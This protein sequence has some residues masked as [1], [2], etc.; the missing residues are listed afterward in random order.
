MKK[1]I[2]L[3]LYIGLFI[4]VSAQ[5]ESPVYYGS[6]TVPP[7]PT[8]A[9]LGK[10]GDVPVGLYTGVPEI[11]IPIYNI[12]E[13][14]LS[15]PISLSY[16]SQGFKV[17]DIASWVGLGWSLNGGGTITR[18]VKGVPDDL[19]SGFGTNTDFGWG[20][21]LPGSGNVVGGYLSSSGLIEDM[22]NS[23]FS[24][25]NSAVYS[26]YLA[27]TGLDGEPDMFYF[28][29]PG[30]SGQFVFDKDGNI[31]LL[32]QQNF[33][34]AYTRS[35]STGPIIKFEII[36][37]NGN[38]YTFD[39]VEQTKTISYTLSNPLILA[40]PENT[41]FYSGMH[42]GWDFLSPFNSSWHLTKIQNATKNHEITFTYSSENHQYLSGFSTQYRLWDFYSDG[43]PFTDKS[44]K[45]LAIAAKRLN[46]IT[47]TSGSITFNAT[48]N[49][50][51]L[52]G[53]NDWPTASPPTFEYSVPAGDAKA[54]SNIEIKNSA[55]ALIKKYNF[56]Y[57][58]FLAAN[59][60]SQAS[61]YKK[62][63]LVSFNEQNSDL[64]LTNPPYQFEYDETVPI[65]PRFSMR[66]DHW[67]YLKTTGAPNDIYT[68]KVYDYPSD[69]LDNDFLSEFSFFPRTTNN[70]SQVI[71]GNYDK[72]PDATAMKSCILKKITYP[73]KGTTTFEFE[74]HD[75]ILQNTTYTG[76]GLRIKKIT[77]YD[78]LDHDKDIIKNYS[79]KQTNAP[80]LSSGKVLTL[81]IF[82]KRG[83]CSTVNT[84]PISL[85]NT[86]IAPLG[87]T[88][89]SFVGYSEVTVEYNGNGK[90]ISKFHLPATVG[91]ED[92]EC[93][94]PGNCIYKRTKS[95]LTFGETGN[96]GDV[97]CLKD[98]FPYA[99]NPNYDWN[100][101]AL[102]EEQVFDNQN[103]MIQKTVNEYTIK[104]YQ[105]I[106]IITTAILTKNPRTIPPVNQFD[107]WFLYKTALHYYI[108]GW[109]VLSKQTTTKYDVNTPTSVF[110][111]ATTYSYENSGHKQIT[112]T[113]MT[114]SKG[115]THETIHKR[116][117]DFN[118]N[119]LFL[120][121]LNNQNR[122]NEVIESQSWINDGSRK[123][124]GASF[125]EYKDFA[126]Q[127]GN[128]TSQLLP[129]KSYNLETSTS[130]PEA[131]FSATT[132]N[133]SAFTLDS[134]FKPV[135]EK[136]YDNEDN[137][138][139]QSVYNGG[140]K[141]NSTNIFG[142]NKSLLIAQVSNAQET[143]C[144]FTSFESDDQNLWNIGGTV[145][146]INN[147]GHCGT[148]SRSI[149]PNTFGPTRDYLP[150]TD[151]QNKK[152]ILSCWVKTNSNVSGSI[153]SLTLYSFQDPSTAGTV[154]PNVT[155]AYKTV[156]V[157][158]TN[159]SWQYL[160]VE[161]DL[162][163]IKTNGGLPS[164]T[165]LWIRSYLWNTNASIAIQIDD[166]RFYPKESRMASYTYLQGTGASSISDE[167]SMSQYFEYDTFGRL[168]LV[169]DF[170][171]KIL[172]KTEYNYKP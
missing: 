63:K 18:A 104:D 28:N 21:P 19:M 44:Y 60:G 85:F 161:I 114:D 68:P 76:G 136:N 69:P 92:D 170:E 171:G 31:K 96:G 153:G 167:N 95:I 72:S 62:L 79:Y 41:Q 46:T 75:F 129:Y 158:N 70:S 101:G 123:L 147:D 127:N 40:D 108:T 110:N 122:L 115:I 50:D 143:D 138:Q 37:G 16:H 149:P 103:R 43:Q 45:T 26:P 106:N 172:E 162:K 160:E 145:S 134:R 49:R 55:N 20:A 58:Y 61:M 169:K 73:T 94:S 53:I 32:S 74:P 33:K 42:D 116:C 48:V 107:Y 66:Q 13:G 22:Y 27:Y 8:S 17:E 89:G 144:G 39:A 151:V 128:P 5:E 119:T 139:R 11:S 90:T 111:A 35:S 81:P 29:F 65:A 59:I 99:D 117:L 36:D 2:L 146:L 7:S 131:N 91:I 135:S 118:T 102:M 88:M 51:D 125:S 30:G 124:V 1:V 141:N 10:Y 34:F 150:S 38:V 159:N 152:M 6:S 87:S 130:I 52:N 78:G 23:N 133:S 80:T 142:H 15:V 148:S 25:S 12:K 57:A 71:I 156:P 155:G 120:S 165:N 121:E 132:F 67:G 98:N 126:S 4:Q 154:W 109:K 54:L 14:N 47:W 112:K 157:Y 113:T 64:S 166:I 164:N 24:N 140:L 9:G 82:A 3:V 77:D 93:S 100:R 56:N 97:S 84:K 168:K 163:Q 137:L 86:S 83:W 105:K